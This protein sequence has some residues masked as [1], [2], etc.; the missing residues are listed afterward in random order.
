MNYE[1]KMYWE[2]RGVHYPKEIRGRLRFRLIVTS[3][4]KKILRNLL[5]QIKP[6]SLLVV[7]CGAGRMFDIYQNIE[8][9]VGVDFSSTMLIHAERLVNRK[10]YNNISL[11]QMDAEALGFPSYSFD[12]V[13]TC[14]VLLHVPYNKIEKFISEITRV[15]SRYVVSLEYFEE[16]TEEKRRKL[17][18]HCFLHNYPKMFERKDFLVKKK[19]KVSR[20]YPQSFFLFERQVSK[21]KLYRNNTNHR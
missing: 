18:S 3:R 5:D 15:S 20:F 21:K 2:K 13:L 6:S 9:V 11:C 10:G 1:P 4:Q 7:G 14:E 17:A 16:I 19:L 12:I 8:K